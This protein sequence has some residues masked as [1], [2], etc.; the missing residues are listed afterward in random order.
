[1]TEIRIPR[2]NSNDVTYNLVEWL[3]EDGA[4]VAAGEPFVVVE[5]S[6]ATE[7]LEMPADGHLR[8]AAEAGRDYAVG[9]V[10]AHHFRSAEEARV[11][12]ETDD[13][14][15]PTRSYLLTNAARDLVER[16]GISDERLAALGRRM[17]RAEDVRALIHASDTP[18]TATGPGEAGDDDRHQQAVIDTVTRSHREIPAAFTLVRVELAAAQRL[19]QSIA[20]QD[21]TV[22]GI[23]ELV[24]AA[25]GQAAAKFPRF[26]IAFGR[27]RDPTANIAVGVTIDMGNGLFVPVV[28]K[29]AERTLPEIAEILM[30]FRRKALRRSFRAQDLNDGGDIAVSLHNDPDVVFAQPIVFPQ[31]ACMVSVGAALSELVLCDD[32]S[33]TSRPYLHLGLS[34]DHRM[35]NGR[36]AAAFLRHLKTRIEDP[37]RVSAATP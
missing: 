17:V 12:R 19:Q 25:V 34:Y 8:H 26:Y 33:V 22:V 9:A 18:A 29:A 27:D 2:L 5:T 37:A 14:A 16:H 3:Q 23:P 30:D 31:H 36:E 1:M 11:H 32:G 13:P 24:V 15:P 6:K 7:E 10:I 4:Q 35:V 20:E 21:R 28:E